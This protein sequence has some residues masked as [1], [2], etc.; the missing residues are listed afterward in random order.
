MNECVLLATAFRLHHKTGVID[1]IKF[2][3]KERGCTRTIEQ[4]SEE[5]YAAEELPW[6]FSRQKNWEIVHTFIEVLIEG[7]IR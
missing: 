3:P 6:K 7:D 4:Y 1:L 5:S 2:H